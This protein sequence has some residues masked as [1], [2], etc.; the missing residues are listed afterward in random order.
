MHRLRLA[1]RKAKGASGA[2]GV[3]LLIVVPVRI[4]AIWLVAIWLALQLLGILMPQAQ[5]EILVSYWGHLGGFVAGSLA[6]LLLRRPDVP[7]FGRTS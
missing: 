5:G 6:L 7:L 3:L 2:V 1:R 4:G